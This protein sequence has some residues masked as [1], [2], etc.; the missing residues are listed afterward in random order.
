LDNADEQS[1]F[2]RRELHSRQK[3][4]TQLSKEVCILLTII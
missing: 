2:I 3:I 4:L 1:A